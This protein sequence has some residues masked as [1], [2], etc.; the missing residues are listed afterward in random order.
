MSKTLSGKFINIVQELYSTTGPIPLHAPQFRGNEKKYLLETIDSTFV[1]SVGQFV[2]QFEKKVAEYTGA[3]YAIS[4]VNGTAAL[5]IALKLAG[6]EDNSEIIT[7]SFTFIATC[8]AIRYCGAKPLFVDVDRGNLGLSEESLEEFLE[9]NTE[10]RNDGYCWNRETNRKISV[11]LPM[12]TFGFP[13][14]LDKIERIC[15]QYNIS[16][17]EDAAESLGS[18]YKHR[19][20]GTVGKLSALS[21]N[22]NKIITTGGGGIILTNDDQLAKKAK[23]ITTTAKVPHKWEFNHDETG[24]NYRLPNLNAALGVAQMEL[25]PEYLKSKQEIAQQYQEWGQEQGIEFVTEQVNTKA[26][27]WLNTII[28]Q[29]KKQRDQFLEETNIQNVMTRPAWIPMHQLEINHDCQYGD[30]SNTEWLADRVINVPSS[31]T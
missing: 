3:K 4:T 23:H 9:Q 15:N 12:H 2:D 17:I 24:Y 8:N 5:H 10:I 27:Y 31:V 25:L 11:C 14:E 22:G 28:M 21:F 19:H 29:D 7:Q 30:M 18:Y 13:V 20:T 1:S 16:L 26:N 6:V